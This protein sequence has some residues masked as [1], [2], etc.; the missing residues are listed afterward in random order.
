M[1]AVGAVQRREEGA[2][3][4]PHT[5]WREALVIW[6][7]KHTQKG[8]PWGTGLQGGGQGAKRLPGERDLDVGGC[9]TGWWCGSGSHGGRKKKEELGGRGEGEQEGK[10]KN[11]EGIG[12]DGAGRC[13]PG[14]RQ[15]ATLE[16]SRAQ[17]QRKKVRD[18][19]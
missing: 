13:G 2:A 18:T 7:Q 5:V 19:L 11:G 9:F 1:Q 3:P 4:E 17:G 10:G 15:V 12:E 14:S 16:G 8:L 6:K